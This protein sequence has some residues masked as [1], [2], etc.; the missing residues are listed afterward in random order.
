MYGYFLELHKVNPFHEIQITGFILEI[1]QWRSNGP[2]S[3]IFGGSFSRKGVPQKVL[4][5]TDG[6]AGRFP[7]I[8]EH[9][10]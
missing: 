1:G 3:V 6:L 7:A 8:L 9:S 4:K 10:G 5:L 2:P